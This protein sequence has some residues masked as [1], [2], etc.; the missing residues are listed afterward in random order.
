M[1][2]TSGGLSSPSELYSA[3]TGFLTETGVHCF[4][5]RLAAPKAPVILLHQF[6]MT[7]TLVL[8]FLQHSYPWNQS[9]R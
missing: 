5:T 8:T 2:E 6:L 1:P 7:Q 3:Q 4:G 9:A